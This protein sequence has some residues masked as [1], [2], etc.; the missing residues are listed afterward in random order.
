MNN[1]CSN[2]VLTLGSAQMIATA[3]SVGTDGTVNL[4]PAPMYGIL[5]ALL[6]SHAIACSAATQV[7]ARLSL[8]YA[9]VNG[10]SVLQATKSFTH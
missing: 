5:I 6:L 2:P 9:V 7:I 10:K 8:V 4:G 1:V 3:I